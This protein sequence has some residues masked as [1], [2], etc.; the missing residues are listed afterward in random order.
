MVKIVE[1]E[2]GGHELV[3]EGVKKSLNVA[4]LRLISWIFRS[5]FDSEKGFKSALNSC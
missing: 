1:R 5:R 2:L 3:E 4:S